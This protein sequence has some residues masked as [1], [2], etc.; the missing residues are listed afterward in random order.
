MDFSIVQYLFLVYCLGAGIGISRL[1]RPLE[2]YFRLGWL[3]LFLFL[4]MYLATLMENTLK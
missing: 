3:S 4:H 2:W 1:T